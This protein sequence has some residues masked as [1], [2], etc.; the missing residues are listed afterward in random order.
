MNTRVK[1][2]LKQYEFT[3]EKW[4]YQYKN[5]LP[6]FLSQRGSGHRCAA[7]RNSRRSSQFWLKEPGKKLMT[8]KGC[9]NLPCVF[10][11]LFSILP[12]SPVI[13]VAVTGNRSLRGAKLWRKGKFLYIQWVSASNRMSQFS[14]SIFFFFLTLGTRCRHRCRSAHQRAEEGEESPTFL[15][16][17][18]KWW[19]SE[20]GK[21]RGDYREGRIWESGSLKSFMNLWAQ[22]RAHICGTDSI[23]HTEDFEIWT[24]K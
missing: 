20:M 7:Q 4:S 16:R 19:T 13:R 1:V 9:E 12:Y 10:L 18:P 14:S 3:I 15:A 6:F 5:I 24:N 8:Q 17:R 11:F 23:H 22:L 21:Y 2:P